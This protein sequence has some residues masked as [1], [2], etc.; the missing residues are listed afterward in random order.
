MNIFGNYAR[1]YDLLNKDKDYRK[2]ADYVH[3]LIQKY[4]PDSKTI[5]DLGC[6]TGRHDFLLAEKGCSVTGVDISEQMLSIA[7][8][9]LSTLNL[10]PSTLNFKQSDIR[11]VRLNQTFDVVISLFH[12]MSYQVTNEDLKAAFATAKVHL[13]PGG[14]FIFDCWYGPAVLSARPSVRVKR[15][16]DEEISVVRIAEPVMQPNENIV[17]VN[18]QVFII[19]KN[20][21]TVEEFQETH[22]MRYLFKPEVESL[23][24]QSG[25]EALICGEWMTDRAPG[26]DSWGVYFVAR[27]L[28][29]V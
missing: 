10:E 17:V 14:V 26:F 13:K 8:A 27:A 7:N 3:A 5:L 4:A 28:D 23:F 2:E 6:G 20:D 24:L 16:E 15:L 29:L 9:Q 25:F 21:S 19:Q 12:V 11:T 1:Y 22:K 18:Y